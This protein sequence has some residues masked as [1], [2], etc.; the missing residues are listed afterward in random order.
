MIG[1]RLLQ[2]RSSLRWR[3]R[4]RHTVVVVVV[5]V[6]VG[7]VVVVVVVG[8]VVVGVVVV[9][10]LLLVASSSEVYFVSCEVQL[11]EKPIYFFLI[12]RSSYTGCELHTLTNSFTHSPTPSL[13]HSL[14]PSAAERRERAMKRDRATEELRKRHASELAAMDAAVRAKNGVHWSEK[15]L[16]EMTERD[17]RI[18]REDFD[19]R[20]QV[21]VIRIIISGI[22]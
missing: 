16:A 11:A 15:S 20:I 6:V 21:R 10:V 1:N 4:R 2:T 18:F 22:E 14:T 12:A 19:I 5:G 3:G 13:T 17:W 7:V 8:V 9:V